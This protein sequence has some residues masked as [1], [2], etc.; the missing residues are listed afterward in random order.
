MLH[1]LKKH[2][3]N[4]SIRF[5]PPPLLSRSSPTGLDSEI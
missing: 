5:L 3:M 4:L 1:L 2:F